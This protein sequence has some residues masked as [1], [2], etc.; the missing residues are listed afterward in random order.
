MKS[1]LYFAGIDISKQTF[2]VSLITREGEMGYQKFS[3]NKEGFML[4]LDWLRSLGIPRGKV[5]FCAEIMGDMSEPLGVFLSAKKAMIWLASPLKIKLSSGLQRGKSDKSDSLLIARYAMRFEDE[6]VMF[7]PRSA[8][9]SRLRELQS[10]RQHLVDESV[11]LKNLRSSKENTSPLYGQDGF[12]ALHCQEML[13][14]L[15]EQIKAVER[16][17]QAEIEADPAI[18][19]NYALATSMPGFSLICGV[20]LIALTDNFTLFDNANQVCCFTGVAPFERQSGTSVHTPAHVSHYAHPLLKPL[21][22]MAAR[23]AVLHDPYLRAYF[24]RI[25]EKGKHPGVAYNNVKNKMLHI[26]FALIQKQKPYD[27]E[28][29]Q[30]PSAA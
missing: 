2:D 24:R 28:H 26:L 9:V 10:Y 3:N 18:A 17:M 7:Q 5:L 25:L 6:A 11:R 15:R 16:Q 21:L 22:T 4:L 20:T 8:A 14:K 13:E 30:N 27:P 23:T 19:R 29:H 1:Y 12:L